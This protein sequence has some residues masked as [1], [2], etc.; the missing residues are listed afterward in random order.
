MSPPRRD[1]PVNGAAFCEYII[2]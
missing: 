2:D 1:T